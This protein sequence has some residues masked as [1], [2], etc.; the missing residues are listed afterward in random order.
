[1]EFNVEDFLPRLLE[2]KNVQL[3]NPLKKRDLVSLCAYYNVNTTGLIKAQVYERLVSHLVQDGI[4]NDPGTPGEDDSAN[5]AD[6]QASNDTEGR[7]PGNV[8]ESDSAEGS[9]EEDSSANEG[10][11]TMPD[12]RENAPSGDTANSPS[13]PTASEKLA[14]EKMR[15]ECEMQRMRLQEKE[16]E[17]RLRMREMEFSAATVRQ[18]AVPPQSPVFD[19]SRC[20]RLVPPFSEKDVDH[21]FEHFEKIALNLKWPRDVW[22]VVISSVLKG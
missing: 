1:M 22:S 2:E 9:P 8:D 12:N 7:S 19:V 21:Y 18:T 5:S 20:V 14:I 16:L 11:G 17:V 15:L 4:V 3:L 6:S 10:T 13:E